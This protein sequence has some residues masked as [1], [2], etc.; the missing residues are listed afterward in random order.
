[1]NS[2]TSSNAGPSQGYQIRNAQQSDPEDD[3]YIQSSANSIISINPINTSR[4]LSIKKKNEKDY[5]NNKENQ[6]NF[7][8]K[9]P[10]SYVIKNGLFNYK[11]LDINPNIPRRVEF[12]CTMPKCGVK[13]HYP[14]A[15]MQIGSSGSLHYR[16]KHIQIASN[17][18]D[19]RNGLI[20]SKLYIYITN[21]I[22][23][24]IFIKIRA[25]L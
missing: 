17:I 6:P 12:T 2:F 8:L 22:Y 5:K 21:S 13:L 19:K 16:E 20:K 25:R 18:E 4:Q 11:L 15:R 23:T 24:N 1:M 7:K 10:N 14:A 9:P 3:S